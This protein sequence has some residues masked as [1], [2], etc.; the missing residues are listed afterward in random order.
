VISAARQTRS[1]GQQRLIRCIFEGANRPLNASEVLTAAQEKRRNL[2]IA[3]VYRTIRRLTEEGLLTTVAIAGETS[4]YEVAGREHHHY[5]HCCYCRKVYVI[6][7]CPEVI[8]ELTP[9]GF[10]QEHHE[11]VLHGYCKTCS[12]ALR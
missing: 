6:G 8:A 9:P 12:G 4:Y 2:G 11:I 1:T 10:V 7:A 5:F 3:T